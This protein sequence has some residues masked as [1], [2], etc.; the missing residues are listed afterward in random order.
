ML[1]LIRKLSFKKIQHRIT[2]NFTVVMTITLLIILLLINFL[3]SQTLLNHLTINA[4]KDLQ[5]YS[6]AINTQI[7]ELYSFHYNI[8]SDSEIQQLMLP[9]VTKTSESSISSIL[10]NY[11]NN[12]PM[13]NAV[14]IFDV[15]GKVIN[16]IYQ[17][18]P[19]DQLISNY[20]E[21]Y[22]FMK[23]EKAFQLSK[24]TQFPLNPEIH[25]SAKRDNLSFFTQFVDIQSLK[26]TGYLLINFK[27]KW[28]FEE[29]IK[30]NLGIF[31]ALAV[32]DE[33][34]TPIFYIQKEV[35]ASPIDVN[36]LS[37]THEKSL[38][39]K[40]GEYISFDN[41]LDS[42]DNWRI[43][44]L[45]PQDIILNEIQPMSLAILFIGFIGLLL[46]ALFNTWISSKITYPINL[47]M[48]SFAKFENKEW[49]E[50]IEHFARDETQ[51]LTNGVNNLF[52]YIQQL[53]N[54]IQQEH[55]ENINLEF[56]LLQAQINPHF[57]HNTMN[58]LECIALE[59]ENEQIATTIQAMNYLFRISISLKKNTYTV[60]R[61]FECIH[62]FVQ[63]MKIRYKDRFT[64]ECKIDQQLNSLQIPKF[65]LQPIVE[66]AIFH[67]ILPS[68]KEG[69]ITI[70]GINNESSML[71]IIRDNGIGFD[72]NSLFNET[73][74]HTDNTQPF[75]P[76]SRRGYGHIGLSNIKDRLA[77]FYKDQY[78]FAIESQR[79]KGTI[80]T[81]ELP[82]KG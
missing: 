15:D 24:P 53:M 31:D 16:P 64:Y 10:K 6:N 8:V 25:F 3:T 82:K 51:Q 38:F 79:G 76:K 33:N 47:V 12:Y 23:S 37:Q 22:T 43:V 7:D 66:N 44:G 13:I 61:E 4:K 39:L 17:Q 34:D 59:E 81:I 11:V 77:L 36:S 2:F 73:D 18:P 26:K 74:I 20:T 71:F 69:L 60:K 19:Y 21:L 52:T 72:T 41:P 35:T 57:I 75:I 9:P 40:R 56:D 48:R 54:D 29:M 32:L 70:Y 49:P 45:M 67:G 50:P 80:I 5:L 27:R 28:V 30:D 62:H 14:F 1:E 63:I 68:D 42:Y 65:L 78:G 55:E 58:A 46:M